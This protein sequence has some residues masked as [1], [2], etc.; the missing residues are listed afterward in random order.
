MRGEKT[1]TTIR[2][3]SKLAGVSVATVSRVLNRNGYVHEDTAKKVL[4]AI[5]VLNYTPNFVARS[6]TNKKTSTIGL[7]VPDITNPFF[8]ELARAIED[9]MQIYAY[10]VIL[11]NSDESAAKEKQYIEIL[12]QKYVDGLILASNGLSVADLKKLDI[13]IVVI[14]RVIDSTIPTVI[15][16][17]REGANLATK[18]LLENGCTKIAH[19]RGPKQLVNA[20]ERYEGY[21][22]LVQEKQWYHESLVVE[23]HYDMKKAVTATLQLFQDHPDINGI[24]AGNDLMA[25]GALKAAHKLGKSVPNELSIIGYDGISMGEASF[26]ELTTVAQPIYDMGALAARMLIKLLE[27]KPLDTTYCQL[28]VQLVQ[29][30]TTRSV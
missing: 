27:N 16:K 26:P 17:N 3:V 24:F 6:L 19:I 13:P 8:P 22:D 12:K 1:L 11:C 5:K 23:G 9:V 21:L 15:S 4:K 20:D 2:D 30:G 18:H 25:I 28:D 29:R 14:D 10:T 7:V